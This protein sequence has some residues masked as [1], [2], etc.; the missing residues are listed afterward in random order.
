MEMCLGVLFLK[1]MLRIYSEA[2]RD[3]PVTLTA[4]AIYIT[5]SLTFSS[6]LAYIPILSA[7]SLVTHHQL[8]HPPLLQINVKMTTDILGS[9]CTIIP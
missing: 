3:I 2:S 4:T 6:R 1:N 7:M 9:P 5:L 8:P